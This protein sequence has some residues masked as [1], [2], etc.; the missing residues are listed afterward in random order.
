M[1]NLSRRS[2]LVATVG[3][4]LAGC[5]R[6][7]APTP[8]GTP[9]LAPTPTPTPEVDRRPRWPLTGVVADDPGAL[10]RPAVAVKVPDNRPE[11]PQVG[12]NDAD[13][14]FVQLDG[15]P[16]A[17]GQ[18]STRLM[19]V[20]HS[21]MPA[22]VAPVRSI[23]PVDV[24]LLAPASVVLGSTGATG[25]VKAYASAHSQYFSSEHQYLTSKGTGAYSIDQ[26]RVR[27]LDGQTYYDRAVVCHPEP[28]GALAP[29]FAD[30][31]ARPYFPFATGRER[32]ST[33]AGVP[34]AAVT[35]PWKVKDTYSMA[36]AFDGEVYRRSMPWGPHVLAD[37]ERVT[38][39]NILVIKAKQTMRTLAP[40]GGGN[41]PMHEIIDGSGAFVYCHG[42]RAVTGTWSKAAVDQL[43]AFTLDGGGPL[44]MSPGRTFVELAD[45]GADVRFA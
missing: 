21:R 19:P 38:T 40:G 31:P 41:E 39:D 22:G 13:I 10:R 24:P 15:Y 8:S 5:A 35:V 42:G 14:V 23:R 34:A 17:R 25:W 7:P 33:D 26:A 43:F 27:T 44:T 28:L 32:P 4:A 9:T 3:A 30:G 36:Y 20:Y 12:I 11:H 45:A 6:P 2:V 16:D 18:S 29:R 1:V 37:Q